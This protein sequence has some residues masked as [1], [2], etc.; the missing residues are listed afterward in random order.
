MKSHKLSKMSK[1]TDGSGI[2]AGTSVSL[3]IAGFQH[4]ALL[5]IVPLVGRADI[6]SAELPI[7]HKTCREQ[8]Q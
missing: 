2:D 5:V 6:V 8:V 4:S 7:F 1:G 3:Y